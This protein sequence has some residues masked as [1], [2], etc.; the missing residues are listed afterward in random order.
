MSLAT[1][2]EPRRL[3]H[4]PGD[5]AVTHGRYGEAVG[6][7]HHELAWLGIARRR[8]RRLLCDDRRAG[9]GE[10]NPTS[11]ARRMESSVEKG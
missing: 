11:G 10:A 2:G 3:R 6:D 1:G 5:D 8:R 7:V 9:K 4:R